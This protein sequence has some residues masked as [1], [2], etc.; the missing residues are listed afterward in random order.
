MKILVTGYDG[1]IGSVMAPLLQAAGHQVTG[2]DTFFFS[3][4][5]SSLD[6]NAIPG[7]QADIRD[8]MPGLLK[9]LTP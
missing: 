2:L 9:G 1:F 6:S 8:R 4:V 7:V 5:A 3:E